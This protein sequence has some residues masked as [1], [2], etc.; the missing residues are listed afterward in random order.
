MNKVLR[1]KKVLGSLVILALLAFPAQVIMAEETELQKTQKALVSCN[2]LLGNTIAKVMAAMPKMKPEQQK[3]VRQRVQSLEAEVRA[4]D[5]YVDQFD[6][7]G[8]G[9][10]A[11]EY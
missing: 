3:D 1:S 6:P 8:V 9:Y 7:F 4:L 10:R 11:T 2:A 5:E